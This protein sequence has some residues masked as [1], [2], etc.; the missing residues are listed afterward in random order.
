VNR[1]GP[2]K[3]IDQ[4]KLMGRLTSQIEDIPRCL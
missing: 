3:I 4:Y 1:L 2:H